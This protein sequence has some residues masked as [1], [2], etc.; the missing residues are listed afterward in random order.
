MIQ[1][2]IYKGFP[3]FIFLLSTYLVP[4]W[5]RRRRVHKDVMWHRRFLKEQVKNVDISESAL[6]SDLMGAVV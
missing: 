2:D 6:G 1:D 5:L 3:G 4:I